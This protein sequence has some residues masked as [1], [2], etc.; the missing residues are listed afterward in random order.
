MQTPF[1]LLAQIL[2]P[3]HFIR[4]TPVSKEQIQN[5]FSMLWQNKKGQ[6]FEVNYG[7]L[8][9]LCEKSQKRFKN[10]HSEIVQYTVRGKTLGV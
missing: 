6:L 10:E 4:H 3:S 5:I 9:F 2:T 7:H 8:T 1:P